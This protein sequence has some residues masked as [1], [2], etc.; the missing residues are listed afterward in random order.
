MWGQIKCPKMFSQINVKSHTISWPP[1]W[2]EQMY[3]TDRKQTSL[4]TEA[5]SN[6][7][8]LGRLSPQRECKIHSVY[9]LFQSRA[10]TSVL[11]GLFQSENAN[12]DQNTKNK[13]MSWLQ[14]QTAETATATKTEVAGHTIETSYE[15]ILI[16]II[17]FASD[18]YN[19]FWLTQRPVM[20]NDYKCQLRTGKTLI[21]RT[22]VGIKTDLDK[23]IQM[24]HFKNK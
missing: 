4:S 15:L 14:V 11:A 17:Q 7:S 6:K 20:L 13:V 16:Q 23:T 8:S 10:S 12:S 9:F 5:W 2:H 24:A 19:P 21:K 18:A 1:C 22:Q 3:Q